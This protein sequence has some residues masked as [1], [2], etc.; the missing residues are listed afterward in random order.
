MYF[1]GLVAIDIIAN[2]ELRTEHYTGATSLANLNYLHVFLVANSVDELWQFKCT[3]TRSGDALNY[4]FKR[5]IETIPILKGGDV[6]RTNTLARCFRRDGST[7]RFQRT[8]IS[9]D[10]LQPNDEKVRISWQSP[11]QNI[12]Q[13]KP[14]LY[15][16]HHFGMTY[17]VFAPWYGGAGNTGYVGD[18]FKCFVFTSNRTLGVQP[19]SE[20]FTYY[21]ISAI[22]TGFQIDLNGDVDV[23]FQMQPLFWDDSRED[24]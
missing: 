4:T 14:Q 22:Q 10:H 24:F 16:P 18:L 6:G 13:N 7:L 8:L 23:D 11:P 15:N 2:G 12:L 17:E 1:Q 20:S 3:D 5:R 9:A 21:M 19:M